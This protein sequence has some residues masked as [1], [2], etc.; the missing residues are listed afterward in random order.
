MKA[1]HADITRMTIDFPSDKHKEL[2]AI[3]ALLGVPM[4]EFILSCVLDRIAEKLSGD[5]QEKQD[6]EAFDRGI[7]SLRERGGITLEEMKKR[8]RLA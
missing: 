3:A 6:A 1:Y 2:K 8:L 7:K 5:F 4:K